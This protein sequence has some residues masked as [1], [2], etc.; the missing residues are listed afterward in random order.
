MTPLGRIPL[1]S[2]ALNE[3]AVRLLEQI[4]AERPD[5]WMLTRHAWTNCR[6]PRFKG[7]TARALREMWEHARDLAM[8]AGDREA[9]LALGHDHP[10]DLIERVLSE[11]EQLVEVETLKPRDGHERIA[12]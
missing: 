4:V 8:D 7:A 2:W 10:D 9:W 12:A 3:G 1:P 6:Q 11:T 5:Y